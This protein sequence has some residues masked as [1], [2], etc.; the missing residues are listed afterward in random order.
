MDSE[1]KAR[2]IMSEEVNAESY[3]SS[4][5]YLATIMKPAQQEKLVA[6]NNQKVVY[7]VAEMA[8]MCNPKSIFVG[9]F[10]VLHANENMKISFCSKSFNFSHCIKRIL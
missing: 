8:K 5:E 4:L 6:L 2:D 7:V 3:K 10:H 9:N 1:T